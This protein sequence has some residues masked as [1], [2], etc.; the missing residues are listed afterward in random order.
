VNVCPAIVMAPV[1]ATPA[2][3]ATVNDT[4]PLPLPLADPSASVIQSAPLA[5]VHEQLL[6]VAVTV[7]DPGPPAAANDW[8]V[9][10]SE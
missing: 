7:V 3:A 9:G 5:A 10:E 6:P 4:L 1:R 2:F 8:P